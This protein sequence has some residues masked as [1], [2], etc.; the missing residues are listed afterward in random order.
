M[1]T[2]TIAP[3]TTDAGPVTVAHQ[4]ARVVT[5]VFSPAILIIAITITTGIFTAPNAWAG[6]GWG[7]LAAL[8]AGVIP[9]AIILVGVKRGR[10]GDKHIG[11]RSQRVKPL[12]AAVLAVIIGNAV[13]IW[14]GAPTTVV[15]VENS[16]L[17]GLA[18]TVPLT[19]KWKVSMHAAVAACTVCLLALLYGPWF[20]LGFAMVA[21]ICW[22]RVQLRDHTVAQVVVGT[23]LGILSAT[24]LLLML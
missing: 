4:A 7:L 16:M 13:L 18:L 14:L 23:L 5:E 9:Y 8:F 20:L 2:T 1:T 6:L 12:A 17:A 21:A 3:A 19:A 10:L 11:D 24:P 15:G 22:S